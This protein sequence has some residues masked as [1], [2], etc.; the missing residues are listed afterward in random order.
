MDRLTITLRIKM[1]KTYYNNGDCSTST[2]RAL[3]VDFGL[4]NRPTT[5]TI[6]I[7]V[8]KFDETEVITNI[9]RPVHH[10]FARSDE[11]IAIA[12]ENVA[13]VPNVS[14]PRHS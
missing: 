10:R 6:G 13:E 4:H 9:E 11:N 2:Y 8:K 3:R 7:I 14:I 1:I 5:Q 12:S